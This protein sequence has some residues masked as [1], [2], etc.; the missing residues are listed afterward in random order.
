VICICDPVIPTRPKSGQYSGNSAPLLLHDLHS[1]Q[2]DS[3]MTQIVAGIEKIPTT[4]AQDWLFEDVILCPVQ[5]ILRLWASVAMEMDFQVSAMEDQ[6]EHDHWD[7]PQKP[8]RVLTTIQRLS[9]RLGAYTSQ[10]ESLKLELESKFQYTQSHFINK[11]V[12][13]IHSSLVTLTK[14]AHRAVP[15][16]LAIMSMDEA[17]KSSRLAM[18]VFLFAPLSLVATV[19]SIDGKSSMTGFKFWIFG[20]VGIPLVIVVLGW[21][22]VVQWVISLRE[23]HI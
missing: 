23:K 13:D 3:L 22:F 18:L 12:E 17:R 15:A 11:D 21:T 5:T 8:E 14:R 19:L 2:K 16:L 1:A 4:A 10:V 7:K 9:R 6:L 20:M